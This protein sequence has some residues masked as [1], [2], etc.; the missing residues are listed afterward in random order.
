MAKLVL[1]HKAASIYDDAPEERYHFPRTY[2]R[3]VEAGLDDWAVYYEP[4]RV[5]A[6]SDVTGGR[7]AYFAIARI[8]SIVPDPGVSDLFYAIMAK[9]SYLDFERPVPFQE[10]GLYY[11]SGL[12]KADGS[13]NKGQAGRSVRMIPDVEFDAILRSG[14]TRDADLF[15]APA[16]ALAEDEAP[17]ERPMIERLTVRPFRDAAFARQVKQAYADT[18]AM[19]GLRIINGGGRSEVQ[20]AHIRP[21][22]ENGP[23]TVRNG[24]ALCGTAHWMFDRGLVSVDD[25]LTIL[26]AKDRLPESA[27][28]LLNA[29]GR[30]IA[31]SVAQLR[32]HRRFLD[33]HRRCVFKG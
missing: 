11:E 2:L 14:F 33:W 18:C 26:V 8:E 6:D 3:Q 5:A 17:F 23:D 1:T 19:T 31:P 27:A 24:L 30:L 29:D 10:G 7:Q 9:G 32:P 15:T 21:V 4:R 12:R 22:T 16:D 25:D 13:T 20:A 28:R